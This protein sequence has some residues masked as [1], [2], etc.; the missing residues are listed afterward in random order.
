M[1][2]T[3]I[4]ERIDKA[5]AG[6]SSMSYAQLAEKVF[7]LD[8]YPRAWRNAGHGGP[9]GCYRTLSA[10]LRRGGFDVDLNGPRPGH[11]TVHPRRRR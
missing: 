2:K 8:E 7:P 5:L 1:K 9:P 11:R 6:R 4:L 10:A 3:P